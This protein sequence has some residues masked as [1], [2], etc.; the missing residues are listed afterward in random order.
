MFVV[1]PFS[2]LAIETVTNFV[3]VIPKHQ[4]LITIAILIDSNKGKM[5][6]EDGAKR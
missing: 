6:L 2:I 4:F 3:L 5:P 1:F